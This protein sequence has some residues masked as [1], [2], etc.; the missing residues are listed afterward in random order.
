[1]NFENERDLALQY[2]PKLFFDQNEPFPLIWI[3]Y[4]IFRQ[5]GKSPSS[6]KQ[7]SFHKDGRC[8]CIEYAYYYDY[9]IQHLYDLEH[10]WVYLN[11]DGK[12]C[13]CEASFHGKYLNSMLPDVD[14]LRGTANVHLY[15]QPGKH[16]FM[17]APELFA[18]YAE[19]Y[20]GCREKA[21]GDGIL[22]PAIIPG[23]PAYTPEEEQKVIAYVKNN[24]AFTPS[25]KYE[26]RETDVNLLRPWEEVCREIPGR[27]AA[28]I[29]RICH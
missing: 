1:M 13:G 17:P 2:L 14:L 3:G 12:V 8:C 10:I 11:K 16:A 19:F 25:A 21:G 27:V 7:I 9:D 24:F 26:Y 5:A 22:C 20:E 6:P 23:M 18:L 29:K 28:E 15:V 4:T